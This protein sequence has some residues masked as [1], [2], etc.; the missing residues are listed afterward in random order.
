MADLFNIGVSALKS[1]SQA[2]TVIGNNIAN[3]NTNGF[4]SQSASFTESIVEQGGKSGNGGQ[5][6]FGNGVKVQSTNA[7]WGNGSLI[8]TG[9]ATDFAIQG[10]GM[11]Q[12][13]VD[14]KIGYTRNTSFQLV[15]EGGNIVLKNSAGA[16]LCNGSDPTTAAPITFTD[17]PVS[18]EITSK[19]EVI[20]LDDAGNNVVAAGS[21][22]INIQ[23]FNNPDSL[24]RQ[25]GGVY[26]ISGDTSLGVTSVG[27]ENGAGSFSQGAV[28]GSNV[29]IATEM[30][31]MMQVQSAYEAGSK[32]VSTADEMLKTILQMS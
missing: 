30:A 31:N 10:D 9:N 21:E 28:E 1:Q 19:G 4:K 25:V 7:D 12:V 14:G 32:I 5:I 16:V 18:L 13:L 20:A 27:G 15:E 17:V 24:Q 8:P 26:M 22:Q 11:V 2:L 6:Q 29:D 23:T 3:V